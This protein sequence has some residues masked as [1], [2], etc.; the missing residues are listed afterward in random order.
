M[1]LG[2]VVKSPKHFAITDDVHQR[3]VLL[4]RLRLPWLIV[5]LIGG[6]A[7]SFLVSRF[8]NVLSTNL[9]LVFFIPVIV[10]LSDAVGTQTETIYI[11]NM[12][13]FK[14]NFAK[15]LAKEILVGSFLGVILSL[16][17]GL[18][19]FIWLRSA[20]TAIT[21]G[22]AMF[23]NTIIAP[24]VAIVIPEILFK[25]NIDPALGGGPFTT[26]IQDFVSLLIYFLVAT[27]IIL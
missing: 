6:L 2:N 4:V 11:R 16:L 7:I 25:Q 3:A 1:D 18:A 10:Y 20:E 9:Y 21:V 17:L 14:D 15:Y 24:V 13:T 19:A 22:F 23:I 26:V 27:V 5:G 8:E 12:S